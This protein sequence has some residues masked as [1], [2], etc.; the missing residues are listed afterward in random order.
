MARMHINMSHPTRADLTR[1]LAA[2]NVKPQTLQAVAALRCLICLRAVRPR[3]QAPSDMPVVTQFGDRVQIDI[4]FVTDM[5]GL[6]YPVL[7]IICPTTVFH[8]AR[9]LPSR[10]PRDVYICF[11]DIW[12]RPF[13][14]PRE[15]KADLDGAFRGF[16]ADTLAMLGIHVVYVPAEAHWQ[17][18][19]IERH[20]Y[21]LRCIVHRSIDASCQWASAGT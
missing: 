3:H 21:I 8:Q 2:R 6:S 16:F 19:T 10:D 4:V 17:L 18:A 11:T 20:N 9:R 7:G 5:N 1:A 13:G 15:V 12:V 14:W